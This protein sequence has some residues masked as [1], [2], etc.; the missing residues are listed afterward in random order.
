MEARVHRIAKIL[1]TL[2][3]GHALQEVDI[4]AGLYFVR[5]MSIEAHVQ[6]GLVVGLSGAV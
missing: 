1:T 4:L 3:L 2:F 5:K 6:F